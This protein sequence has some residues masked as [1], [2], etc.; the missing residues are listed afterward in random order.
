MVKPTVERMVKRN[1]D[2]LAR[3]AEPKRRLRR[4]TTTRFD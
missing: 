3:A 1:A 2:A 4:A